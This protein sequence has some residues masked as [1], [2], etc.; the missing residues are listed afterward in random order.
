MSTS[1]YLCEKEGKYHGDDGNITTGNK[2]M[3]NTLNPVNNLQHCQQMKPERY[4]AHQP[5]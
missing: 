3:Q 4:L 5:Y 1:C 2:R